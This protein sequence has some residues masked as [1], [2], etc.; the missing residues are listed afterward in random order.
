[1]MTCDEWKAF[2]HDYVFGD[3][4]DPARELLDRHAASCA[5][6]LNEAGL[7]KLVDRRLRQEPALP[8]P[9]GLGK[10]ALEQAPAR[11]G[12]EIWRVAAALLF[13]GGIG[14]W[15]V[16]GLADRLPDDVRA[17]PGAFTRAAQFLPP[18]SILK[19]QP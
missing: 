15:S 8:A 12:R 19:E 9:A 11:G 1:M 16:S 2:A 10:R 5:S 6:C 14:A 4:N 3:L 17:A 18:L 7:L 13:A